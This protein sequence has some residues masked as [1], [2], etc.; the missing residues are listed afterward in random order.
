MSTSLSR[1]FG[2]SGSSEATIPLPP[3][4]RSRLIYQRSSDCLF[5]QCSLNRSRF[6]SPRTLFIGIT[7]VLLSGVGV[8]ILALLLFALE[9][10]LRIGFD[11]ASCIFPSGRPQQLRCI[12]TRSRHT[13]HTFTSAR[14]PDKETSPPIISR[15]LPT[16]GPFLPINPL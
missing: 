10:Q 1:C 7:P 12:G 13:Q 6:I 11:H 8:S 14:P 3:L 4:S 5:W 9:S 2:Q 15:C 16:S